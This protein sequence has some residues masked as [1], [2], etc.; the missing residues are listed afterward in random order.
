MARPM[1][2]DAQ[3]GFSAGLNTVTAVSSLQPNQVVRCENA[4]LT[5]FGAVLKRA[6]TQ[7]I[8]TTALSANPVQRGFFWA[9]DGG[10]QTILA[11]ANGVL[12]DIP[13]TTLPM[14]A[15]SVSGALSNSGSP[16]FAKFRDS[17]G[18]DVVYIADGGGLNKYD[19][20]TLTTNIAST[21]NA[22]NIIVHNERL[23][24][25]CVAGSP[26]SIFYSG[27]NDGD[28]LGIA[29]GGGG[30][31]IV[32]T[33]GDQE[34]VGMASVGSSLLIFHRRGISR[35]T[36]YGTEDIEADPA[37]L[38]P[39]IGLVS[40]RSIVSFNNVV[41]FLTDRGLYRANE[42]EVAPVDTPERPDPLIALL[43]EF[44]TDDFNNVFC[45]I[46]ETTRELSIYIPNAGM[47]VYN[48]ILNA[49]AGP[50]TG[51]YTSTATSALFTAK[52]ASGVPR[53]FKGSS[54][55][56]IDQCDPVGIYK[57]DT[58]S[59]GTGGS[60][61]AMTVKLHRMYC[62]DRSMS[63]AWRWAYITAFSDGAD[64]TTFRWRSTEGSGTYTLPVQE[65]SK[66]GT[67][68]WGAG[69]WGG[70][71]EVNYRIPLSFQGTYLDLT[72][73]DSSEGALP[74]FSAALLQGFALGRR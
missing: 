62:G 12:Y 39:D 6:G 49:W 33:F 74:L 73:T 28:T 21:P 36:G 65:T 25:C 22:E 26:G 37:A 69:T 16:S 63:K 56:W 54:I 30:Q 13:V 11:V 60:V 29:A 57:D 40:A 44:T 19:G 7:R 51:G 72:I 20:T 68:S 43:S 61:V 52:D 32:R 64:Q 47:Y 34:T 67:G 9:E 38:S 58:L 8:T 2:E 46:N 71:S 1:V 66:W 14:T 59:D 24:A 27:L 15:S 3:Q 10:G 70:A 45:E 41:Y 17:G 23:W 55:G 48:T 50:F 53:L 4:R 35:L 5:T 42:S 31:I 18:N